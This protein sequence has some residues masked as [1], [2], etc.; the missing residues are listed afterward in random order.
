MASEWGLSVATFPI[1]QVASRLWVLPGS[2]SPHVHWAG[3]RFVANLTTS[4]GDQNSNRSRFWC[5]SGFRNSSTFGKGQVEFWF[6]RDWCKTLP[7]CVMCY[8]EVPVAVGETWRVPKSK[9]LK[10]PSAWVQKY[11][12]IFLKKATAFLELFPFWEFL[13]AETVTQQQCVLT[14]VSYTREGFERSLRMEISF[15]RI[16]LWISFVGFSKSSLEFSKELELL[17]VPTENQEVR[18]SLHSIV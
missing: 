4:S 1:P 14:V 8:A 10:N 15:G 11:I 9:G 6:M 16:R 18:K 12:Y 5:S 2:V 17:C 3:R 13:A 7:G